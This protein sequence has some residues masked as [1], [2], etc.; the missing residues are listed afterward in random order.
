MLRGYL[1][2]EQTS[3]ERQSR[4]RVTLGVAAS[5]DAEKPMGPE[6]PRQALGG[7]DEKKQA[8]SDERGL[9]TV[10]NNA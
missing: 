4:Y 7:E 6:P 3:P 8:S 2:D 10:T 5:P 1:I 9:D